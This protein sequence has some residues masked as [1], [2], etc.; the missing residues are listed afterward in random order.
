MVLNYSTILISKDERIRLISGSN[1]SITALKAKQIELG[2]TYTLVSKHK[3]EL[4]AVKFSRKYYNK[5]VKA[6]DFNVK[7][8]VFSISSVDNLLLQAFLPII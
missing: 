5:R 4:N 6:W 7:I 1:I 3:T 2:Y 8:K